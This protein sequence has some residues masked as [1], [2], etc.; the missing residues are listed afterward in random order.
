MSR[1]TF[2]AEISTPAHAAQFRIAR[3][4]IRLEDVL[5]E[6]VGKAAVEVNATV[7]D[8]GVAI[9]AHGDDVDLGR[10]GR[11]LKI[12]DRLQ[13]G[14]LAF[15]VDV[16][17]TRRTAKGNVRI[18]LF[19]GKFPHANGASG[20]LLASFD[21]KTLKTEL[22]GALGELGWVTL[23]ADDVVLGGGLLEA[24]SWRRPWATC[25][26]T[27]RWT[28]EEW[29]TTSSRTTFRSPEHPAA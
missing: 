11:L 26:S 1:S 3:G 19:G 2:I 15:D 23:V 27:P 28:S 12:E 18:D 13:E 29:P 5:L 20:R 14:H 9:R 16:E 22:R 7:K 17:S 25:T 4:E 10:V 21:G 24:S 6:G 8:G